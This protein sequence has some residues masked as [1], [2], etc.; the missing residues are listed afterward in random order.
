VSGGSAW[1]KL[2]I[3]SDMSDTSPELDQLRKASDDAYLLAVSPKL[4]TKL[5]SAELKRLRDDVV[6]D[7]LTAEGFGPDWEPNAYGLMLEDLIDLINRELFSR[8]ED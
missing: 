5:S 1:R 2:E 8:E 3:E 7:E 6:G 4:A